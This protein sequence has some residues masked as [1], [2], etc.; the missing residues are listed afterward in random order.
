[1]TDHPRIM[2]YHDGRHPLI[3]MYEPPM[4]KEEY[5][6]AVDELAGTTVEA[7]MFCLGDGRTVLHDTKVGELWGHNVE[8]WTHPGFRR[9]HQNARHLID[10]GFDPLRIVCERAHEK[11]L[12]FYPVLLV[13]QG[14][15]TREVDVRC[16]DF[17]FDNTHLE[18]GAKP[19]IREDFKGHTN[20]DFMHEEVRTERLALIEETLANYDVDGFEL[21]MNYFPYYFHPDEVGA[22]RA[23]MTEWVGRVHEAVKASGSQRE[24][25]IRI[26]ASVAGCHSVGMDVKAW[27]DAGIVDVLVGQTFSGPELVDTNADYT[28][29]ID[30]A[31]GSSCQ[32]I[33]TIHSHVDSDRLG[34]GPIA[35]TRACATNYWAQGVDGLYLA[36][37]FNLWPYEADF[38][39]KLRELPHPDI[40]AVK[41]K[42][43]YVPTATGRY[44]IPELEPGMTMELPA[45][46][47]EGE[48]ARVHLTVSD[49]LRRWDAVGRV[50]EVILRI[51]LRNATEIDRLSFHFND[52]ELPDAC[53]RKINEMY[54]MSRPRFRA[55]SAYWFI[56][57]LD[58]EHWPVPGANQLEIVLRQRDTALTMP[59]TVRDVELETRYLMGKNYHRSFVDDDLGPYEMA[60][61]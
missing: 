52:T 2:F 15:G 51:R 6:A 41:D 53:L 11:G 47:K 57:Q 30:L 18:I 58:S 44:P 16:S 55:G 33:G 34:E 10:S 42:I 50:H 49:D 9:A 26:P 19:G 7:I 54:R 59:I 61:H 31:R 24:L 37:W 56:Y 22:G 8:E 43:Y 1:M 46:L 60:S 17:R 14:R 4:Q 12:A 3:Y 48:S 23:V 27:I 25:V 36:H 21:Q 40:M 39:Q 29:L 13:Q 38:Y 5:E 35:M 45:E 28:E 20:L 32:V